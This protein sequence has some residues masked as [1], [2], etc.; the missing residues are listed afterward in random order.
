MYS[1]TQCYW[2]RMLPALITCHARTVHHQLR[3]G[4]AL[5]PGEVP[6]LEVYCMPTTQPRHS[7]DTCGQQ[8]QGPRSLQQMQAAYRSRQRANAP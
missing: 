7:L 8:Q 1:R 2:M 6:W 4:T 3:P 5:Q